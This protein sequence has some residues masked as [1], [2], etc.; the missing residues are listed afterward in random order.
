[1]ASCLLYHTP[2]TAYTE[3]SVGKNTRTGKQSREE[4]I[5]DRREEK[6]EERREKRAEEEVQ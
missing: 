2:V 3:R 6:R 1:M 5:E 4:R